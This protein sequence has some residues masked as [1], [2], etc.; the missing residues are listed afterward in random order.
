MV[1][2]ECRGAMEAIDT[3]T[4]LQQPT[5]KIGYDNACIGRRRGDTEDDRR[6]Q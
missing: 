5:P 2:Q 1:Q 6:N 3:Y 4:I